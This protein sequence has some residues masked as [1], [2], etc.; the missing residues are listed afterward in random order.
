MV[1][2][3]AQVCVGVMGAIVLWCQKQ[4]HPILATFLIKEICVLHCFPLRSTEENL[5]RIQLP[6]GKHPPGVLHNHLV[7]QLS[8]M[9]CKV[10]RRILPLSCFCKKAGADG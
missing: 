2:A 6:S 4:S 1:L 10:T 7:C 5:G 3:L 8:L 9:A